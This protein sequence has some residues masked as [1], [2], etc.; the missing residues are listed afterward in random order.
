M[1]SVWATKIMRSL[2][3]H[4]NGG[5]DGNNASQTASGD[6]DKDTQT[7]SPPFHGIHD[8]EFATFHSL[9]LL[10]E[11]PTNA[12]QV[13]ESA[14]RIFLEQEEKAKDMVCNQHS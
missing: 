9:R 3:R 6:F 12:E 2:L 14:K 5:Q 4:C 7:E 1:G 11:F 13:N 10:H 8:E